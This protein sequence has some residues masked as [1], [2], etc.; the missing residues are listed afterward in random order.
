MSMLSRRTTLAA[1][2]LLLA[3]P[4]LLRA[5][6]PVPDLRMIL[7][8]DLHS[9]YRRT[10]RLAAAIQSE[11]RVDSPTVIIINGDLLEGGNDLARR[12]GGEAD[13][14][15]IRSLARHASVYVTIGNHDCDLFSLHEFIQKTEAAGATVIS[16]ITNPLHEDTP[17]AARLC[18]FRTPKGITV[19]LS[20]VATDE[21]ALYEKA[22]RQTMTIPECTT[23]ANQIAYPLISDADIPVLL[24]HAGFVADRN[25]LATSQKDTKPFLLHG[26]HDHLRFTHAMQD[27]RMHLQSGAWT[28]SFQVVDAFAGRPP[29]EWTVRDILTDHVPHEDPELANI[30]ARIREDHLSANDMKIIGK[31]PRD[32]NTD[33]AGLWATEQ[34]RLTTGA[35]AAFIGHTTFGDGLPAGAIISWDIDSFLR[36]DGGMSSAHIRGDALTRLLHNRCNQLDG[37]TSYDQRTGDYLYASINPQTDIRPDKKYTIAISSF[38]VSTPSRMN[39]YVGENLENITPI[40]GI[41]LRDQ[42]EKHISL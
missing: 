35:D 39:A 23:Y 11:C 17:Y 3:A 19:S 32:M 1:S 31:L 28:Q 14:A 18:R 4:K 7:L 5:S 13:F 9:G 30:I 24:V 26:S 34:I 20:A 29:S 36:F 8:G 33:Q 15:L 16:D 22:S 6:T 10:A 42:I 38:P 40:P 25:I 37:S 27:G 21:K 41:R 12:S 2:A